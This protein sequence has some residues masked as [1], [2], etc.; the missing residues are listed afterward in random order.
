MRWSNR[1]V[2]RSTKVGASVVEIDKARADAYGRLSEQLKSLGTAQVS[3]QAEA[4]KL[5]TALRST[6]TAGTWGE[7][8]LRRVVEMSGMSSYCDFTEQQS[9]GSFRPD[10]V[11]RLPGGQQIVI[12]AK[13]PNDAYR[14]AVNSS[15][16]SI[17]AAKLAS[18][19]P[20]SAATST[21]SARKI[22]GSSFSPPR[23]S[24]SSSFPVINFSRARCKPTRR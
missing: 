13:A 21:C 18:T 11:V 24:S 8:Q 12:D 10:L 3:L 9:V 1:C 7:L 4:S 5:T 16:E 22:I 17:R 6:N 2:S 23:S 19:P 20:K 14:E 15:D